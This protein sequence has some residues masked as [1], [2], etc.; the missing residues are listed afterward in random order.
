MSAISPS[1]QWRWIQ[2]ISSGL[3]WI[4]DLGYAHGDLRPANIFLGTKEEVRLGDFDSTVKRG[5]QLVVVSEPFCKMNEDYE[6]PL[7]GPVTEQFS[8]ASCIYT[9]RF[10]HKPFYSLEAP[11]RVRRLIMNQFPST[12]ADVIIGDLT[13]KCW[14]GGYHS[15]KAVELE[16]ISLLEKHIGVK[17]H[18]GNDKLVL[19]DMK[20]QCTAFLEKEAR[21]STLQVLYT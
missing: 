11:I 8:L 1:T 4:E 21:A 6:P 9:I 10:G 19:D 15:V 14:D 5:E 12:K 16:V 13:Q 17:R 18:L 2:Q 3:A 7:A 20:A